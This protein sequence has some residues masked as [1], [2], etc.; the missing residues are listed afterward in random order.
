[1]GRIE[2]LFKDKEQR[3]KGGYVQLTACKFY[4]KV[5]IVIFNLLYLTSSQ[6][7]NRICDLGISLSIPT[8]QNV[9]QICMLLK[10]R[11]AQTVAHRRIFTSSHTNETARHGTTE[12]N[13]QERPW[14]PL[15]ELLDTPL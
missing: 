1:M 9:T 7:G 12:N 13:T 4:N 6:H 8:H 15:K 10:Q 14:L 2:R 11:E 3:T 5:A